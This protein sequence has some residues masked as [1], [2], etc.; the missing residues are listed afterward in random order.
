[1][2]LLEKRLICSTQQAVSGESGCGANANV[3]RVRELGTEIH[4]LSESR[5]KGFTEGM[6]ELTHIQDS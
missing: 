3:F 2:M 5:G 4:I 6:T 1:M